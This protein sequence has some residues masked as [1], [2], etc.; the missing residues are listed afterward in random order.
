MGAQYRKRGKRS[1]LIDVHD[2][3]GQRERKT[4]RGTEKDA[5]ELCQW[6]N[7]QELAGINVVEQLRKAHAA[8]A[9]VTAWP[10]L[11]EALPS[12]IDGMASKGEWTG[13]TPISYRRPWRP[14]CTTSSYQATAGSSVTC[15]RTR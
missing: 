12:F 8:P 14:T 11:R 5:K 9:P 1:W 2:G 10:R 3:S 13:S 6:I 7:K 4:I 15:R